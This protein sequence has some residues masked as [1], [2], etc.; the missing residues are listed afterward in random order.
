[1]VI[2]GRRN[3]INVQKVTWC[4]AEL[5]QVEGRDYQRID[6]GLHHGVND[7]DAYRELNPTGLVPTLV[8]G[9]F[10]LWESNT[11]VRYLAASAGSPLLPSDPKA[12][13][14][15]ERWMDWSLT[16]WSTLR[17][18]FLGLT[19]TPE[20]QQDM[21][22]IRQAFDAASGMLAVPDRQLARSPFCAGAEF[23]VGDIPVALAVDRWL[24]LAERFA[25]QLGTRQTLPALEDWYRRIAASP[26][27]QSSVA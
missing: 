21:R 12:R 9:D 14:L 8:D 20:A 15:S 17:V 16:L 10:V 2:Y 19:R 6:A 11:I 23:T 25:P 5:G 24:M 3:S 18:T 26:A 1:M 22:A 13:A 7:T 27:F 4:L